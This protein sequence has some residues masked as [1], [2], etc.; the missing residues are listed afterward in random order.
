MLACLLP[1]AASAQASQISWATLLGVLEA[2]NQ[3]SFLQQ[4]LR[5]KCIVAAPTASELARLSEA[6]T[7]AGLSPA[8]Q[9]ALITEWR[10]EG[11][12]PVRS[13]VDV[14]EADVSGPPRASVV[15]AQVNVSSDVAEDPV[16]V[17]G[18][19]RGETPLAI[20]LRPGASYRVQV[21]EGADARDTTVLLRQGWLVDIAKSRRTF[22]RRGPPVPSIE[23]LE[24]E[25]ATLGHLPTV[26]P[27]PPD[28][29]APRAPS[30]FATFAVSALLGGAA[31]AGAGGPCEKAATAPSPDGGTYGGE[32]FAPGVLVPKVQSVC[33][34]AT[35]G[36]TFLGAAL[37]V[38]SL[39]RR[40]FASATA[41]HLREIEAVARVTLERNAVVARRQRSIDSAQTV[42]RQLS[43]QRETVQSLTV[44][45]RKMARASFEV[46]PEPAFQATRTRLTLRPS[47]S[48]AAVRWTSSDPEVASVD[49]AGT[50][51]FRTAG[52]VEILA[53]A[54]D[55]ATATLAFEVGRRLVA[56]SFVGLDDIAGGESIDFA[57]IGTEG[58]S[59]RIE[60]GEGEGDV[61]L[62][63]F[64]PS[65][66]PARDAPV[67]S[68]AGSGSDELCEVTV[69]PGGAGVWRIRL[70]TYGDG[71]RGVR[72]RVP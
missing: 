16:R 29:I 44:S 3:L 25:L 47:V 24:S 57:W 14:S 32:Y 15:D 70:T 34:Q 36:A 58:A 61:D 56:G 10:C 38:S 68:S 35:A 72:L 49:D 28:P 17:N 67:C 66:D 63:V 52:R 65:S 64:A 54:G 60:T 33:S 37:V 46:A 39:K 6:L 51:R 8:R 18:T 41:A 48:G 71:V 23:A 43:V 45:E 2:G 40:A 9:S 4:L 55:G 11:P 62:R 26:P 42:R 12:T 19:Y 59:L 22:E 31:Y 1:L 30:G 53:T 69:P 20:A 5:N 21:G 13:S 50:V 27:V 7:P